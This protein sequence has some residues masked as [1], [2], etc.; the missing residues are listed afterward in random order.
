MR[1]RCCVYGAFFACVLLGY[2]SAS[3]ATPTAT[4]KPEGAG[5][6]SYETFVEDAAVQSGLIPVIAKGGRI[7]LAL[8]T[9]QLGQDFI[10]TSV[11]S[12]GLG[13]YGPAAGEPYVAPARILRFERYENSVVLRW[14]NTFTEVRPDTPEALGAAQSFPSSVIAV[15]PI[16]AEGSGE[17]VISADAFLGD[18][19]DYEHAAFQEENASPLHGYRLDPAR[20]FFEAT[21]AFPENDVLRVSQTWQSAD[22][23]RIDTAPDARSLEIAMTYNLIEAPH[24][25]YM[26]R[27]SDSRVGY[28]VTPFLNFA[29]DSQYSR[30]LYYINRWNFAPERV[31]RPSDATH[32]M[33]YYLSSDIPT[34]YRA[35][36]R[37]A[38]LT[39]NQALARAGILN[40]IQV[41][42]QPSDPNWDPE[43]I[44]HNVVRWAD[45][46][47]SG[48]GAEALIVTDPRTGELLNVGIS[49]IAGLGTSGFYHYIIA[50]ERG[51]PDNA[52]TEEAYKRSL[53]FAV[54]LHESGHDLGLQHNFMAP[55]AYTARDL[56]SA[57]FTSKY[58][59]ASS[60]MSYTLFNLWPRGTPEGAL[61][62][63][64]LGPYDYHAV[65]YGYGYIRA[66]TPQE[67]LP[68]LRR[69]A[70]QWSNPL[71]RFA[72][73]E[74]ARFF[75]SGHSIDPR[76][77]TDIL[78][79]H[80][81]AWCAVQQK[82]MHALMNSVLER[83][84]ARGHSYDDAR[85]A[86]MA[87]MEIY[88]LCA[89]LPAHSIGGEYLS[90]NDRGDPDAT[91]PLRAVSRGQE[92]RAWHFLSDWVLSDATWHF[93]P[94]VLRYLTYSEQSSFFLPSWAYN[95]TPRHDIPIVEEA[96]M[97]QD[98]VLDELLAPVTLER[99]DDL[100]TKYAP[101][102]TM[103]IADLFDWARASIFGD[104]GTGRVRQDGVVRRN[105]QIDYA[106]RLAVLW[107][108]PPK[109]VPPDAQ[110][111][112]RLQLVDLENDAGAALRHYN[113]DE[114][115]QAHLEGLIA[116][117]RE[118]L[119]AR[120]TIASP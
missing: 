71:Y 120:A 73:D 110:M 39:W 8:S 108:A 78:T 17:V 32:P 14:P 15:A 6:P 86:F 2:A 98:S 95:Q 26:P 52:A 27:L 56:Q 103:S 29:S 111:I 21:K 44:R 12:N 51:L 47:G 83:F 70:E 87:P 112:A 107:T 57:A 97:V 33:V 11:P 43:D 114:T 55:Y 1:D 59:I 80:P 74:D 35:T 40:A 117:A 42:Q 54:T 61:E 58:G 102:A 91:A 77:S 82:M 23:N 76:A 16:V 9:S 96:A 81:L 45:T 72:S 115:T 25:G 92:L 18:V 66:S 5:P 30:N 84:P 113:F 53:I 28:F 4:P 38:L 46:I 10:E 36:V 75:G 85:R 89:S 116:I 119:E 106:K 79:N 31:G 67:E 19:G 37:N 7:Y 3:A 34:Q 49:V 101:G 62:Q 65:E 93:N 20:T 48:G 41:R 105:L 109:G 63:M 60:V 104:I 13:G 50:P 22:P 24:D 64:V 69:I 68:S 88:L 90:R 118:A 94:D 99:I 100:E